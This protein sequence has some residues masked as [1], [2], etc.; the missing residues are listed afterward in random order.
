MKEWGIRARVLFLALTPSV[1]ILVALV[2]Y[3]TY[4]RIAEVDVALAERGKLV[5]RRLAPETEFAIFAGDRSTLQRMADAAAQEVDV[6]AIRIDDAQ[7]RELVHSGLADAQ[8]EGRSTM[9]FT[10]TVW[11]TR[12]DV[13]DLADPQP[14]N[15][16]QPAIGRVTVTMTRETAR[17]Q[18]QRLLLTGLALGLAGLALA[19]TL[20]I[21]IGNG[22]IRPIRR[23]A[24]A[25][26]ELGRGE[27]VAP[28]ATAG[29]GELSTL[30]QGFNRMAERLQADAI[31]LE[32]RI[33]TATQELQAQKETAEQATLAKSRFIAA[34]SHDLRQP[35]HAI[36]LF[37]SALQRQAQGTTLQGVAADLGKAVTAME[38]LFHSLLDI[39]RLDA[40]TLRAESRPFALQH[41]FDQIAAEFADAAAQKQLKFHVCRTR[42]IVESDELL[43]HRVLSNLVANAIRYTN[44]GGV[45]VCCRS[46]DA[47]QIEVRDSGVGIA[48]EM[49]EKIFQEF[50]Q[51]SANE[52]DRSSGLGLGLAIV[53]RL[54]HLLGT[55]VVVRSA[56]QRGST[57]SLRVPRGN[58]HSIE[59]R[60]E[61]STTTD[62]SRLDLSVL[63]IDDDPLVLAGNRA[64][65]EE[66][67]CAVTTVADARQAELTIAAN[68]G[69]ATLVLC[70]MW[71]ANGR[72]G[73]ELLQHLATLP[74]AV[75]SSILIS[76]DTRPETLAA[77]VAAGYPLLHKPMSPAKLR[78]VVM[79]FANKVRKMAHGAGQ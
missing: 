74:N 3:F 62:A 21:A 36:G 53:A 75:V 66:L 67:G 22:V 5:A 71:L 46:R 61:T 15:A 1:L 27:R 63:V 78:A 49:H 18:Q 68:D 25:M 40:G 11:Q 79:N 70:D 29:S 64:L 59:A 55:E 52:G 4:Q 32:R 54:A 50:Y 28:I 37:A 58:A 26:V 14:A 39:S 12:L 19:I 6:R 17:W 73:I 57:F 60:T 65:L 34:A 35:L 42:A 31:E 7:G 23:L 20:A 44:T 51:I 10:E 2:V 38:R 8:A 48:P 56:L 72:N 41:L 76:G 30:T 13:G 77:A 9:R 33:A 69:K 16:R 45:L 24:K 47:V 43:L